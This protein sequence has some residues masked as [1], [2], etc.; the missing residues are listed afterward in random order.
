MLLGASLLSRHRINYRP[1]LELSH[2]ISGP[3]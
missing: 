2:E 3:G 1:D